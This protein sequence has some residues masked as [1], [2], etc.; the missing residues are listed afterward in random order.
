MAGE[1]LNET[2]DLGHVQSETG[3]H[4]FATVSGLNYIPPNLG[5]AGGR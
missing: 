5:S 4:R 3:V 1:G 2:Q